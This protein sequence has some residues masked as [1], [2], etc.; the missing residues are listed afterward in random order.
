MSGGN[1]WRRRGLRF[2]GNVKLIPS[3]RNQDN[4]D[5][6]K[7]RYSSIFDRT[8]GSYAPLSKP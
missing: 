5:G 2:D 7:Q 8:I 1:E 3:T 6:R 4:E